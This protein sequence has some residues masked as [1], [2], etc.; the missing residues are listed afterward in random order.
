MTTVQVSIHP[1]KS[2]RQGRSAAVVEAIYEAA[3]RILERDGLAGFN[4]NSVAEIAGVSVGSL[5]Q[6][7]PSK[8]AILAGLLR[9]K[10]TELLSGLREVIDGQAGRPLDDVIGDLLVASSQY[11]LKRPALARA[12]EYAEANLPL[13]GETASLKVDIANEIATLLRMRGFR[14]AHLAGRDIVGIV[15]GMGD[16]ASLAGETDLPALHLRMK[17]AVLGYLDR[18]EGHA[19]KAG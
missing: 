3:T 14:D 6:Y 12:L 19:Q 11:Q 5:Y 9:H 8:E 15:R 2:P 10:R 13:D 18:L 7:F 16:T 4:T 1:R 17:A